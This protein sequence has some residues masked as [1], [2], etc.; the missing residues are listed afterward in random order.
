ML[1][2]GRGALRLPVKQGYI[3]IRIF[4]GT[5][6]LLCVEILFDSEDSITSVRNS[7]TEAV[8]L[9]AG[10]LDNDNSSAVSKRCCD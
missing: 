4:T 6:E 10:L 2:V 3:H 5:G 9:R 1:S 8:R 7:T